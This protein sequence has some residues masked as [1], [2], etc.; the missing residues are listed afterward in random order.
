[1]LVA[2]GVSSAV[3]VGGGGE[4]N[5]NG[6][7]LPSQPVY[8][9]VSVYTAQLSYSHFLLY[10]LYIQ[11]IYIIQVYN[12]ILYT[13]TQYIGFQHH[14]YSLSWEFVPKGCLYSHRV[15]WLNNALHTATKTCM[16]LQ[17]TSPSLSLPSPLPLLFFLWRTKFSDLTLTHAP[18]RCLGATMD[19]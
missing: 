2:A 13:Q 11:Y 1:M 4:G 9:T 6:A 5:V 19:C 17:I 16:R 15:H 12:Y 8:S 18:S 10:S 7:V 14:T 3:Y